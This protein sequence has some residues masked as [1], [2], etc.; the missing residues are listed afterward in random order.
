MEYGFEIRSKTLETI[1]FFSFEFCFEKKKKNPQVLG[2]SAAVSHVGIF[3]FHTTTVNLK[4]SNGIHTE[5][6]KRQKSGLKFDIAF[7]RILSSSPS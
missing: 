5:A 3:F 7:Q 1:A 2:A 6:S 4:W